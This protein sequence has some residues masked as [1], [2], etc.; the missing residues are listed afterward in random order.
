MTKDKKQI[1]IGGVLQ[2][3]PRHKVNDGIDNN[4]SPHFGEYDTTQ[5]ERK[6][7][8]KK[9]NQKETSLRSEKESGSGN[10]DEEIIEEPDLLETNQIVT[11]LNFE[12]KPV[13]QISD[14]I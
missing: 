6:K 11:K 8:V 10:K 7:S 5:M 12:V 14:R 13:D 1:S 3:T 9:T 2:D 4:T